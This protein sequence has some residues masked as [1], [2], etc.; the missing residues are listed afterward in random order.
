[1]SI[2]KDLASF[3]EQ[4]G[5]TYLCCCLTDQYSH[6]LVYYED[7]ED[8]QPFVQ[9]IVEHSRKLVRAAGYQ[10]DS[11]QMDI[12]CTSVLGVPVLTHKVLCVY[13]LDMEKVVI[14]DDMVDFLFDYDGKAI[15]VYFWLSSNFKTSV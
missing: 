4:H 3:Y 11:Y 5:L 1:M 14:S 12:V 10:V 15:C 8:Y 9:R 7:L 6:H 13:L 2:W